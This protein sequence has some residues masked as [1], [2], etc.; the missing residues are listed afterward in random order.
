MQ[1][2]IVQIQLA[3]GALAALLPLLP[4]SGREE[5]ARIL[6]AI[7]RALA[8]I[9]LVAENYDDLA[10]KLKVLRAEIEVMA[11]A[12]APAGVEAVEAAFVRVKAA[13]EA[14]RAAVAEGA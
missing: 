14:F 12:G 4:G 8:A 1:A 13:S 10:L 6:E 5:A 11:Q 3:L 7:G 2:I 9:D